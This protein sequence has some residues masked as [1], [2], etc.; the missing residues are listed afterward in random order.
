MTTATTTILRLDE[1]SARLRIP[2]ETLRHWR[3]IGKGPRMFKLGRWVVTTEAD[4]DEWLQG[5]RSGANPDGGR[6]A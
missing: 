3:K 4:L 5:L 1:V 6:V 2:V